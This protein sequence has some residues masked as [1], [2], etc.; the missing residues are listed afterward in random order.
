MNKYASALLWLVVYLVCYW[1]V[2]TLQDNIKASNPSYSQWLENDVPI[3][4]MI[5]F[6][7]LFV[8]MFI[9]SMIRKAVTKGEY[10][11]FIANA[12]FNLLTRKQFMI[13]VGIGLFGALWFTS[14][15]YLPF[16][17]TQAANEMQ[18]Y[19][20]VFGTA[21]K[22]FFTIVGVGLAGAFFEEIFF[23]GIV[24]NELKRISP[25]AVV[26]IIQALIYGVFQPNTTVTVIATFL[27]L[28][29]GFIY[30]KVKSMWSTITIAVSVNILIMS[31]AEFGLVKQ[32]ST[33][34]PPVLAVISIA[35]LAGMVFLLWTLWKY[36]N[37]PQVAADKEKLKDIKQSKSY[38]FYV[39][40]GKVALYIAIYFVVMQPL[41]Y[42]WYEWFVPNLGALGEFMAVH[43]EWGL[44]VN[45][46]IVI[47]IYAWIIYRYENR[48]PLKV[49]NFSPI[50][51][52]TTAV[53]F[54]LSIAMGVWVTS[55]AKIPYVEDTF[56]QFEG[57]FAFLLG[58]S[59]V[60][61]LI[62]LIIH[63]IYKEVLFRGLI[64]NA[65]RAAVPLWLAILADAVIYGF[66]FFQL[67]PAL[68]LYGGMGTVIFCLLYVWHRSLWTPIVAQIGLFGTYYVTRKI[69]TTYEI[70]FNYGFI[71]AIL[72]SS[73][74][75]VVTKYYLFKTR[76]TSTPTQTSVPVG[77]NT[78]QVSV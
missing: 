37:S 63:S 61:F 5:N 31:F 67:D 16:L 11:G 74:I 41:V 50:S 51:M 32:F 12:G 54:L 70:G 14:T 49:W 36:E 52:N 46:L 8:V 10:P 73:V 56:P 35:S 62:F 20:D 26:L 39:M 57:L 25:I 68:T 34:A 42:Y 29:Y 28:M 3:W 30:H 22:F 47:P 65:L 53:T 69:Y 44:I 48:N 18:S 43:G 9:V 59:L 13:L 40:V 21:G 38:R 75:V 1:A 33:L 66:L 27:G 78:G 7:A 60:H 17:P 71:I 19:V 72:V 2:F 77:K 4:L 64:F 45:D 6:G 15:M 76:Q 58:P 55:I 24:M 23:R